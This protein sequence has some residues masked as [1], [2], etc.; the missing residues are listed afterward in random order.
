MRK[1]KA[2]I[3]ARDDDDDDEDDNSFISTV[4]HPKMHVTKSE[5]KRL[6]FKRL[7]IDNEDENEEL[8]IKVN[9]KLKSGI[10][11]LNIDENFNNETNISIENSTN[12]E[13]GPHTEPKYTSTYLN[14][15]RSKNKIV[16]S[17]EINEEE[18][19]FTSSKPIKVTTIPD[20]S[21]I[22]EIKRKKQLLRNL[23]ENE[24]NEDI[25][26][27]DEEDDGSNNK[28]EIHKISDENDDDDDL[29]ETGSKN[30]VNAYDDFELEGK[31]FHSLIAR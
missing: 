15:L 2:K 21:A 5:R 16:P 25:I 27:L 26:Y 4:T 3:I 28:R 29:M 30:I 17:E 18:T 13:V 20:Q 31:S 1:L 22:E 19:V 12:N 14:E 11:N 9:F 7:N 8:N 24:L 10:K 6:P 23:K